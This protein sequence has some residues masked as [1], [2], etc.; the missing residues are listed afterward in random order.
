MKKIFLLTIVAIYFISCKNNSVISQD[1]S[2][3]NS[4]LVKNVCEK[5]L[6]IAFKKLSSQVIPIQINEQN[7][8]QSYL[9]NY[10]NKISKLS[11]KTRESIISRL[12]LLNNLSFEKLKIIRPKNTCVVA[13]NF[14]ID[15]QNKNSGT[16][17]PFG[18]DIIKDSIHNENNIRKKNLIDI[19]NEDDGLTNYYRG[20]FFSDEK[21]NIIYIYYEGRPFEPGNQWELIRYTYF[22]DFND[23]GWLDSFISKKEIIDSNA[24]EKIKVKQIGIG[25]NKIS[26]DTLTDQLPKNYNSWSFNF[27]KSDGNDKEGSIEVFNYLRELIIN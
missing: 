14:L 18:F 1:K 11:N 17:V 3:N 6:K 7:F 12:S 22:L 5:D 2:L 15:N 23:N 4:P 10:E 25:Y 26:K 24:F 13:Q 27:S 19:E 8:L 21:N 9:M 20:S 16:Y